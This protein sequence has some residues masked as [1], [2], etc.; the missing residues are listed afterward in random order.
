M[1]ARGSRKGSGGATIVLA[2]RNEVSE[3]LLE[4]CCCGRRYAPKRI[5]LQ[6]RDGPLL[7]GAICPECVLHG[8]KGAAGRLRDRFFDRWGEPSAPHGRRND[9]R[10]DSVRVWM[11]LKAASLEAAG[12]FPLE[13][14]QAAVR[15]LREKR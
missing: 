11:A 8:P 2:A 4:C 5:L 3:D 1:P 10:I 6:L 9:R 14:R 7:F 12:S 13:A 15:A